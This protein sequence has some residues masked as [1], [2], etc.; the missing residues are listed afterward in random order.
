MLLVIVPAALPTRSYCHPRLYRGSRVAGLHPRRAAT[1]DPGSG[2]G[3]TIT[4]G[5]RTGADPRQSWQGR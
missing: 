1:L 4:A 5:E 2:A 3:V